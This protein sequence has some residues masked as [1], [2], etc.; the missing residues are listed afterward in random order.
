MG[1]G[2]RGEGS[3]SYYSQNILHTSTHHI[4]LLCYRYYS[5]TK[6]KRAGEHVSTKRS[7]CQRLRGIDRH[8]VLIILFKIQPDA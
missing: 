3:M 8:K 7:K 1:A 2:V 5:M 6:A 4:L